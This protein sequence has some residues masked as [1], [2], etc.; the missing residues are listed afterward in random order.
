MKQLLI[1]LIIAIGLNSCDN[2]TSIQIEDGIYLMKNNSSGLKVNFMNCYEPDCNTF[3]DSVPYLALTKLTFEID[4]HYEFMD[5]MWFAMET[6]FP[7]VKIFDFGPNHDFD[8]LS[9]FVL[10]LDNKAINYE[11]VIESMVDVKF[12]VALEDLSKEDLEYLRDKL[13]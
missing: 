13:K 8:G 7:P 1:I 2:K 9:Y 12:A 3:I 4:E 11:P 10:V 6:S 5:M